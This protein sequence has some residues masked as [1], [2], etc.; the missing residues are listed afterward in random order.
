MKQ[1]DEDLFRH[2]VFSIVS[3]AVTMFLL[4]VLMGLTGCTRTVYVPA[5]NNSV[6]VDTLMQTRWLTDYR[7]EKDSVFVLVKGDSVIVKD[8]KWRTREVEK[9]DT[10]YVARHDTVSVREPYP[11]EKIVEVEKPL[12][13]WQRSLMWLGGGLLATILIAVS[14]AV[15]AKRKRQ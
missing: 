10:V 7:V 1:F 5:E 3:F 4:C 8:T 12:A 6:R 9:H 2:F 13:W 11:V 15:Y 14:I